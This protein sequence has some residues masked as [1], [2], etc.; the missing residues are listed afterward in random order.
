MIVLCSGLPILTR[1]RWGLWYKDKFNSLGVLDLTFDTELL[2]LGNIHITWRGGGYGFFRSQNS[3]FRFA[4][5][6]KVVV[7]LFFFYKNNIF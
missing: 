3:F 6:Q 7:A 2:S 4:A 5:Q 1:T